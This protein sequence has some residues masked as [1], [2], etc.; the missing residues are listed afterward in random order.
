MIL[1]T[2]HV[3]SVI[4]VFNIATPLTLSPMEPQMQLKTDYSPAY[5][6]EMGDNRKR[7]F[8]L[9]L[10]NPHQCDPSLLKKS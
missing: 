5:K 8:I 1:G 9:S 4:Y 2:Y 10:S 3:S 7:L 6:E